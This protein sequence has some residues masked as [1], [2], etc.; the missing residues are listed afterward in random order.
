MTEATSTASMATPYPSD[1]RQ[2]LTDD[3]LPELPGTARS[4]ISCWSDRQLL[5]VDAPLPE[6]EYAVLERRPDGWN[7]VTVDLAKERP[8]QAV[9]A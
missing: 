2:Q 7:V 9:T 3:N 8:A 6:G 5:M 4:V 1:Q